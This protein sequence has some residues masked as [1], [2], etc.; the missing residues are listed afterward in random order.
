MNP[1]QVCAINLLQGVQHLETPYA[2]YNIQKLNLCS[3]T[4]ISKTTWINACMDVSK[5]KANITTQF[6]E[7]VFPIKMINSLNF[8]LLVW[9]P[10]GSVLPYG[11]RVPL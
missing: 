1:H 3:K 4:D 6:P 8:H 9:C 10:V 2:F 11:E 7:I 5:N